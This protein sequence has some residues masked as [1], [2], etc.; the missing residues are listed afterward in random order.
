[1]KIKT[2]WIKALG[3]EASTQYIETCRSNLHIVAADYSNFCLEIARRMELLKMAYVVAKD[4]TD[5][6]MEGV[7]YGLNSNEECNIFKEFYR[8]AREEARE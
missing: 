5:E 7:L 4:P 2:E 6:R 3:N 8:E 1:M